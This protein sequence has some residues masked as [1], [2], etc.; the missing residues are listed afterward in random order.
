MWHWMLGDGH[1]SFGSGPLVPMA[2]AVELAEAVARLN[3]AAADLRAAA[4]E[5]LRVGA[6][7]C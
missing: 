7:G 6:G 1:G 2:G 4:I 3:D 5:P